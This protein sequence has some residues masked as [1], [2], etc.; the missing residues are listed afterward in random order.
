[1]VGMT[2]NTMEKLLRWIDE[3]QNA[4]SQPIH[5]GI[6]TDMQTQCLRAKIL[7]L[8]DIKSMIN[9]SHMVMEEN[10]AVKR[11]QPTFGAVQGVEENQKY[12]LYI[13]ASGNHALHPKVVESVVLLL[14]STR[15]IYSPDFIMP[16]RLWVQ[17]EVGGQKVLMNWDDV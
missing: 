2:E 4:W 11:L 6:T 8:E 9:R 5:S 16:Q 10:E 14:R 12:E 7:A 1:M 17:S 3:Q 15:S 13:A